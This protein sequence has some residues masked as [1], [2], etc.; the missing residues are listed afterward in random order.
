MWQHAGEGR[1]RERKAQHVRQA[2][3]KN[4]GWLLS[5]VRKEGM[6]A[7]QAWQAEGSPGEAWAEPMAMLKGRKACR[8]VTKS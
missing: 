6:L 8:L 1:K 5:P 2:W 4:H 7:G 3:R